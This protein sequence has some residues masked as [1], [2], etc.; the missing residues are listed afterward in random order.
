MTSQKNTNF[1]QFVAEQ[2][3]TLQELD[4]QGN[5]KQTLLQQGS[6]IILNKYWETQIK[7]RILIL[8]KK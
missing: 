5:L 7:F 1:S 6:I 8:I 3:Q 4:F 2:N